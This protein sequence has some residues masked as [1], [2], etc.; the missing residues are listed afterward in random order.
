MGATNCPETP[1]QRMISMMYLVLTA[2]LALNVSAQIIDAFVLFDQAITQTTSIVSSKNDGVYTAFV[3]A[4]KENPIKTKEWK[5]IAD[6]LQK[7][8]NE[9]WDDMNVLKKDLIETGGGVKEGS[10]SPIAAEG[11]N[12]KDDLN[13][14][15]QIMITEGKGAVLRAKYEE[16]RDWL[17]SQT[18]DPQLQNSFKLSLS[19]ETHVDKE[20]EKHEWQV[21]YFEHMPLVACITSLSKLQSD[22]RNAEAD[23]LSYLYSQID[24][25]SFT[26]NKLNGTVIAKSNYVMSGDPYEADIFLA[27]FDTTKDPDIYI[28]EY[29]S[30][31]AFDPSLTD[32]KEIMKGTEGTDYFKLDSVYDGIG[33]YKATSGVGYQIVKGLIFYETGKGDSKKILKYPFENEYQVAQGSVVISPTKMNVFYIGVEN[34]VD[35]SVPGVAADKIRPSISGGG[36][37]LYKSGKGYMVKVTTPTKDCKISVSAEVN[38]SMRSMGSM[39][40]RVKRVPDPVATVNGQKGGD[41]QKTLLM[42]QSGVKAEMENFDFELTYNVVGFSVSANI[43]GFSQEAPCGGARFDA[44]ALNIIKQV[45]RGQ[46]VYIENVRAKG[47]DGTVRPLGSIIFKLK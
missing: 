42:S 39:P 17:I 23:L 11:I 7:R 27:A 41:I 28:G 19:T 47:P 40:F 22:I 29:D 18:K 20:G 10:E 37:S 46:K 38:G 1:R 5:T 24:A 36:G 14:G 30:V 32:Y 45:E 4:E 12:K 26:F 43:G 3:S 21:R 25:G 2:L 16:F 13:V 8:A 9:I 35:I 15:G 31:K 34:P 44:K 33:K 6:E